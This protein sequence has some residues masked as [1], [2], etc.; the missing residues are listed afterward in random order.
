MYLYS[1]QGLTEMRTDTLSIATSLLNLPMPDSVQ[2]HTKSL[3]ASLFLSPQTYYNHKVKNGHTD[4]DT[5][6]H[7]PTF[8]LCMYLVND[9]DWYVI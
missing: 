3:L 5:L 8:Y 2:S 9:I 1:V 4:T 6:T 7:T